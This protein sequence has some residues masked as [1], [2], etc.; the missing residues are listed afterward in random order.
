[1]S[2]QV[3]LPAPP[4]MPDQGGEPQHHRTNWLAI[5]M[6]LAGLAV[7]LLVAVALLAPTTNSTEPVTKSEPGFTQPG[8]GGHLEPGESPSTSSEGSSEASPPFATQDLAMGDFAARFEEELVRTSKVD[9]I[10]YTTGT[11]NRGVNEG[12]QLLIFKPRRGFIGFDKVESSLRATLLD[13]SSARVEDSFH[14]YAFLPFPNTQP[15]SMLVWRWNSEKSELSD[16]DFELLGHARAASYQ[17]ATGESLPES[18]QIEEPVVVDAPEITE[19]E[20]TVSQENAIRT[21]E[22]YLEYTAFSESGLIEQLRYEKY[23]AADA[24]FAVHHISVDWN[25]QAAKSAK[26]Y[27]EFSSF[28][29]QGLIAQLKYEGFTAQQAIYGVN[30][31]GL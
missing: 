26:S 11:F 15:D 19:P 29:R 27:L 5:A 13:D 9:S 7:S 10:Q 31:T 18:E 8:T 21:A 3:Q 24:R 20:F 17:P 28:S 2:T 4:A 25:E 22:S 6:T 12:E 14:G 30:T 23:S 1:M 16:W